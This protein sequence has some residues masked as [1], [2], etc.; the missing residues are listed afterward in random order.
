[1]GWRRSAR[2]RPWPFAH[3]PPTPP[4]LRPPA[5]LTP[6]K[7]AMA[8]E[9]ANGTKPARQERPPRPGVASET[10]SFLNVPGSVRTAAGLSSQSLRCCWRSPHLVGRPLERNSGARAPRGVCMSAGC[11]WRETDRRRERRIYGVAKKTLRARWPRDRLQLVSSEV[12]AREWANLL[13]HTNPSSLQDPGT[14]S[15]GASGGQLT[16]GHAPVDFEHVPKHQLRQ[17]RSKR[18]KQSPTARKSQDVS[19]RIMMI[20]VLTLSAPAFRC[21]FS[22]I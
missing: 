4:L 13:F 16:Q 17:G 20:T 12:A 9:Q 21:Y 2:T 3:S 22:R 19:S 7:P 6:R 18:R 10:W 1:M 15:P 8:R 14:S 5:P 11:V